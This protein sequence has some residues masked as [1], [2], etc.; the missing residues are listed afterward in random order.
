MA[1]LLFYQKIAALNTNIHKKLR[2]KPVE[3]YSFSG[4]IHSV[5]IVGGEFIECCKEYP[6][7]FVRSTEKKIVPV[8]LL[9]IK[10]NENLFVD[11]N[12][13]WQAKYVP[14][15][16]R[17]YPFVMADDGA[18]KLTVCI[19][20]AYPGFSDEEGELCF[21]EQ[22]EPNPWLK[23]IV[24][25]MQQYQLDFFRTESFVANLEKLGLLKDMTA[26]IEI[27]GG[28]EYIM[29]GL[30]VVD[31][32]KLREL[33]GEKVL[34]LFKSGELGLIYAH[35][36]SMPNLNRLIDLMAKKQPVTLQ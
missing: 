23:G 7:V 17:R 22:D 6:I 34:S 26:K 10:Q 2:F 35:L 13:N 27:K 29:N 11:A 24:D 25:F 32:E 33:D 16:V 12:G 5:V 28:G 21:N 36:I 30:L 8:A 14:A 4:N 20:S 3:D 18:G 15:Y 19:D 9:G 31:E 1:E